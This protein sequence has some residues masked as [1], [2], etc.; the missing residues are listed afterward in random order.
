M[1]RREWRTGEINENRGAPA[2]KYFCVVCNVWVGP[3]MLF[4][5]R[6]QEGLLYYSMILK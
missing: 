5:S 1:T 3:G 6:G 4:V 2:T